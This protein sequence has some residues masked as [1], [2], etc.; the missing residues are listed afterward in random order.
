MK[1]LFQTKLSSKFES[2]RQFLACYEK[3]TQKRVIIFPLDFAEL[4]EFK[5]FCDIFPHKSQQ[6]R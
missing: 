3:R 4:D 2:H 6:S 5:Y 1:S